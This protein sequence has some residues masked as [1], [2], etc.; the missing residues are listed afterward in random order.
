MAT[1]GNYIQIRFSDDEKKDFMDICEEQCKTPS[2]VIRQLINQWV[3][4]QKEKKEP[5]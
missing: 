3:A 2:K 4:E 1:K 5:K